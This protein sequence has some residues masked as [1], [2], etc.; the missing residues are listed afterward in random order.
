MLL[1]ININVVGVSV[2]PI[3]TVRRGAKNSTQR[4]KDT[5]TRR[6]ARILRVFVFNLKHA[7]R[8]LHD[9]INNAI[10]VYDIP[11]LQT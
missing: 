3:A 2:F 1:D 4:H 5:K 10:G 6:V 7:S 9:I 8:M 11:N